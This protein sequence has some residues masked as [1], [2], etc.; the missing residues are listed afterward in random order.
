MNILLKRIRRTSF[1]LDGELYIE[2]IKLCDTAENLEGSLPAGTYTIVRH[3]CKQYARFVPVILPEGSKDLKFQGSKDLPVT[4]L[5]AI[6]ATLGTMEH[7]T[8]EQKCS[9]CPKLPFV[10]NNTTLP[11]HCPQIKAGN[12]IYNRKD[13]SIIVGKYIVPGC[14]SHPKEPFENLCERLRKLDGRGAEITLTI[15]DCFPEPSKLNLPDL[16]RYALGQMDGVRKS[17]KV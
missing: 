5:E 4:D 6:K 17:V 12:G 7:E 3:K 9:A 1:A 14:L 2:D 8:L 11:C 13:G 15:E 16:G 10:C